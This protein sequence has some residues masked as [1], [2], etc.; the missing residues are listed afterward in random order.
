MTV[1]SCPCFEW[2][3]Q[4]GKLATNAKTLDLKSKSAAAAQLETQVDTLEQDAGELTD[5]V[6]MLKEQKEEL[7]KQGEEAQSPQCSS[8]AV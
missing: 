6:K 7:K 8:R 1:L 5:Q 4:K 3:F 2:N